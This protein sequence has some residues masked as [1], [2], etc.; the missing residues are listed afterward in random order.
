MQKHFP[1]VSAAWC[2]LLLSSAA[3]PAQDTTAKE[4]RI[5][6]YDVPKAGGQ[7]ASPR[8]IVR[9]L[10]KRGWRIETFTDLNLITLLQYDI[11]YLSDMHKPGPEPPDGRENVRAYV[12]AGGSVLQTWHH[13]I[14][15]D[16]GVGIRRIYGKRRMYGTP[17]FP[18]LGGIREF[19][20]AYA[21]HIVEKVGPK[22]TVFIKDQD[23]L[24]VAVAGRIGKGK[25]ISTGLSLNLPRVNPVELKLTE[26]FFR[27]LRPEVTPQERMSA[28]RT[29]QVVVSPAH[30]RAAA[31]L[32]TVFQLKVGPILRDEP[33]RAEIDGAPVALAP[34]SPASVLRKAVFRLTAPSGRDSRT[35]HQVRV[36]I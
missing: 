24:P 35:E 27:W 3:V 33:C 17:G 8:A 16:V 28:V 26:A 36:R 10:A 22:G 1:S 2:F 21:D 4:L 15:G 13:H 20:A 14:L 9:R 7:G 23:G 34:V 31:G 5:G 29:P 19:Q 32:P 30:A 18:A 6:V 25:V 11:V 12:R